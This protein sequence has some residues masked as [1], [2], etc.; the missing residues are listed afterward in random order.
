[1]QETYRSLVDAF[2]AAW[3]KGDAES[4][5]ELFAPDGVLVEGPFGPREAGREAIRAY[6]RDLPKNQAEIGFKAGE[7]FVAGPWF[8]TEYRCTY[9][10][11]RTGE[12][13]DVRGAMVC[14]T[15][16]GKIK[17]MRLYWDRR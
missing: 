2:G 15:D 5:A 16:G 10:R 7:I 1:M 4:M 17:E 6:W 11:R 13:V 8:A 3:E 9:R 14:E 12:W